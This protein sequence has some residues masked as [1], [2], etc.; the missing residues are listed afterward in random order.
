MIRAE[1]QQGQKVKLNKYHGFPAYSELVEVGAIGTVHQVWTSGYAL[2]I[3]PR[4]MM[5]VYMDDLD[6]SEDSE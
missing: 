6:I 5:G 4:A 1:I 3:F 2:V